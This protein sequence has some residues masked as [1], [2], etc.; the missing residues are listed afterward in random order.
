MNDPKQKNRFLELLEANQNILHKICHLYGKHEEDRRDLS[1]EI[2]YQLWR[3]YPSFRGEA[4][5]TTWMYRLSLNTALLHLR[6]NR[7][8]PGIISLQECH[9]Q[10]SAPA[11]NNQGQEDIARLYEAIQKLGR[12]DRA[13]IL[14][15]LERLSYR[16]IA[17]ITGISE[18]NVSVRLVR[19][20]KKLKELLH[21]ET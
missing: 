9:Q 1:Q 6:R 14:L 10:I 4:K 17:T 12:F 16:E 13:L 11:N 15:Y 18:G 20:K 3:S 7:R 19:I 21:K 2:V 8:K 5:F